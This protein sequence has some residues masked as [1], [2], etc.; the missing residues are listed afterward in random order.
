MSEDTQNNESN[1]ASQSNLETKQIIEGLLMAAGKPLPINKIAEVFT[2][3]ERPETEELK[4][5]LK[6]IAEDCTSRGF[7]LK[8]VASGY[9]FQVK[10]QYSEWVG[11]LWEEKPQRY[12]RALLE[13]ISIIAYRQPI[14]RGEIE[15]IRGVAVSTNIIR[16]L[17]ER[18]WVRVVGHRDVP[19]KPAMYATTREFLDY[20]N[21]KSLEELPTLSEVKELEDLEPELS[22]EEES[23]ESRV[24]EFPSA[25]DM[26][27][28]F[29]VLDEEEEMAAAIGTRPIEEILGIQE[30]E[31][32]DLDDLDEE[33]VVD[34]ASG[35]DED[36]VADTISEQDDT[37]ASADSNEQADSDAGSVADG[38]QDEPVYAASDSAGPETVDEPASDDTENDAGDEPGEDQDREQRPPE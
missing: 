16:T 21:L 11:K 3:R 34:T 32:N 1:Q 12:S 23:P 5:A 7:E 2:D 8:Q 6:E 20:F 9:R 4:A 13:T 15:K 18:D 27:E 22:L 31:E 35:Q 33:D 19:G 25:E 28:E 30:E 38:E 10:Q 29:D 37:E 17:M 14:T 36:D 26:E 24:L